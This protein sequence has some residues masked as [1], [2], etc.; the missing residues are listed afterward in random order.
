MN[1]QSMMQKLESSKKP[2]V[3]AIN[4]SC[5]GGGLEVRVYIQPIVEKIRTVSCCE[6]GFGGIDYTVLG[7][8]YVAN[9]VMYISWVH[10]HLHSMLMHVHNYA[11]CSWLSLSH[12]Y[13]SP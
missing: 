1:G 5:L 13:P 11:G 4:G 2:V 6:I 7:T 3:A 9:T 12:C 10:I 8:Q